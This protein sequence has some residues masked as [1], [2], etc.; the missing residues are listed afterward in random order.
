MS[1]LADVAACIAGTFDDCELRTAKNR[2]NNR[3]ANLR[4]NH[5]AVVPPGP[6]QNACTK[7]ELSLQLQT[8]SDA[9]V[10]AHVYMHRLI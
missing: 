5:V 3:F 1:I 9:C 6:Q 7:R 10:D 4:P 2:S 8:S